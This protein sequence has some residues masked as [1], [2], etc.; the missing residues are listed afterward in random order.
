MVELEYCQRRLLVVYSRNATRLNFKII[1]VKKFEAIVR[2]TWAI[3]LPV[4]LDAG[5]DT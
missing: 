2:C 5:L 4:I 1:K 3:P